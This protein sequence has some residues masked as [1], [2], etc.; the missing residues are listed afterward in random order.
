MEGFFD[1]A[2]IIAE[3]M[4]FATTAPAQKIPAEALVPPFEPVSVKEITQAE[5]VVIGE[6]ASIPTSNLLGCPLTGCK[7]W[8][9]IGCH[10]ILYSQFCHP[11]A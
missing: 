1:G 10:P 3:A 9:F 2:N 4:A 5:G 6:S 11:R 8:I 7:G